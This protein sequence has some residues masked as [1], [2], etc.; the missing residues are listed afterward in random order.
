MSTKIDIEKYI[1]QHLNFQGGGCYGMN[2]LGLAQVD[3]CA[4]ERSVK[5]LWINIKLFILWILRKY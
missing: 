3:Y 4:R 5:I 1:K 2:K